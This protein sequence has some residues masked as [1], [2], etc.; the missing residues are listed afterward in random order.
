MKS[1]NFSV[2]C[3]SYL[4]WQFVCDFQDVVE[5]RF[6]AE[7]LIAIAAAIGLL[8]LIASIALALMAIRCRRNTRS[9][10]AVA[11]HRRRKRSRYQKGI[12]LMLP[13]LYY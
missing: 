8:A 4:C 7:Y 6:D 5:E 11:A 1:K 13:N 3:L 9:R 2:I 10:S 12:K